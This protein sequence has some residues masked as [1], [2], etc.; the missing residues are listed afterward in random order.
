MCNDYHDSDLYNFG[1]ALDKIGSRYRVYFLQIRIFYEFMRKEYF[2]IY[3][4]VLYY[5]AIRHYASNLKF[6]LHTI[7]VALYSGICTYFFF[8]NYF[9][10]ATHGVNGKIS[11]FRPILYNKC[12]QQGKVATYPNR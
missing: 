5:A 2:L 8:K 4:D 9:L 1:S 11:I 12:S 10:G 7:Y 3:I 6:V